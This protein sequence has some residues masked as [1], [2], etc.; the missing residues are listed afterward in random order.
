M[1]ERQSDLNLAD[2]ISHIGRSKSAPAFDTLDLSAAENIEFGDSTTNARHFTNYSLQKSSGDSSATVS[3]DVQTVVN[4]MN[5]MYFLANGDSTSAQHWFL[6]VGTSDTDT[7]PVIVGNLAAALQ[8]KD[9]SVDA[10]MYWDA[11]HGANDDPANFIAWI[12]KV[13]GYT[14]K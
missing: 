9:Y 8:N 14:A 12:A 5:P 2:F 11:E 3:S 13:T 7:S 4:M 6:R 1:G 10:L